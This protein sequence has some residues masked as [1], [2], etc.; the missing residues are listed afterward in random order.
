MGLLISTADFVPYKRGLLAQ[1]SSSALK[2]GAADF[3]EIVRQTIPQDGRPRSVY[4]A[5]ES[6]HRW[7]LAMLVL[8][9]A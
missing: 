4:P 8:E 6:D 2:V 3:Y 5:A 1:I 7:Q 9:L